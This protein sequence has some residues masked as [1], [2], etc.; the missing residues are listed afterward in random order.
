MPS[1]PLPTLYHH[2]KDKDP[3]GLLALKGDGQLTRQHEGHVVG[4]HE[5]HSQSY[6]KHDVYLQLTTPTFMQSTYLPICGTSYLCPA[7]G[8]RIMKLRAKP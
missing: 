1:P 3:R 2:S 7:L 4:I 8:V 5:G 6:R